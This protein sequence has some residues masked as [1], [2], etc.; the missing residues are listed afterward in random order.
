MGIV[1]PHTGLI[2]GIGLFDNDAMCDD[3]RV[4]RLNAILFKKIVYIH[5]SMFNLKSIL[6]FIIYIVF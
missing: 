6:F 5:N 4:E 3:V 1:I 2:D